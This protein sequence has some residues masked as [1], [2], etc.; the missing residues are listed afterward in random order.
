M[1]RT[2]T[3]PCGAIGPDSLSRTNKFIY[4]FTTLIYA[5]NAII[6]SEEV[7]TTRFNELNDLFNVRMLRHKEY[8][9]NNNVIKSSYVFLKNILTFL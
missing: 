1:F 7:K 9:D 6:I 8:F 5:Y 4:D 3:G 2:F